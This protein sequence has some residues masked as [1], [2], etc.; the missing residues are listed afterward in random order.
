MKWSFFIIA[1]VFTCCLI[2]PVYAESISVFIN[3]VLQNNPA[4][5]AAK[6][7]VTA[8]RYRQI[9]SGQPLYNPVL[10]AEKQN[11]L[12][13]TTSAGINQTIDWVNKRHAREQVGIANAL[14]AEA[15]Y[16]ALRQHIAAAILSA[17][18]KLQAQQNAVLL[19]KSRCDL[20]KQ[21]VN[22]N[23]KRYQNGD[24]AR[25][26]LDLAQ[27]ALSEALAQQADAEINANQALQV[28]RATTGL[29][30]T[31]WPHLP[32]NLPTLSANSG[33]SNNR[34]S[35]LPSILIL[36]QQYQ[37]ARAAIKVA[38]RERYPDPTFGIEGG[39]ATSDSERK[40]L[41]GVT[42]GIP[43][44]IRN[45][46]RAEVH[47]ANHDAMEAE[48]KRIDMVRQVKAEITSSAERYRILSSA[49]QQWQDISAKPLSDG[50]T[51]IKRLWQAGEIN[52]IDY[53]V[54]LKQ[55]I[56]SQIA[57]VQLKEQAWEAWS[58]WLKASG[59]T[60]SW[61]N[62]KPSISGDY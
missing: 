24:I 53:L 28:L 25:V 62:R 39:L 8:S 27:L 60:E 57:G 1:L 9:A 34:M 21:F 15:Q 54:Q 26:D 41:V 58:E 17:L 56:D 38:E 18:G 42:L 4:I 35:K 14:V 11:A 37:V 31:N 29:N 52:T 20:L 36:S 16:A 2:T 13:N 3:Q 22:L 51:L 45:P 55:R 43:L 61:L 48:S 5:Q 7:N 46:Y 10:T 49:F 40:N 6:S 23:E 44:Y 33:L 47:A 30:R 32:S 19:A 59:Q 12:E 50:L